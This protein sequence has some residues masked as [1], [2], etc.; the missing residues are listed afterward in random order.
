M[1]TF[2]IP[3]LL[4]FVKNSKLLE[5]MEK[6]FPT[7]G[8]TSFTSIIME[9]VAKSLWPKFLERGKMVYLPKGKHLP[10]QNNSQFIYYI[11][12][13]SCGTF[14]NT[15]EGKLLCLDIY[16]ENEF[17]HDTFFSQD[18]FTL[19]TETIA[20]EDLVVLQISKADFTSL[21][22]P[23]TNTSL[24]VLFDH[25]CLKKMQHRQIEMLTKTAEERYM[26]LLQ[27]FPEVIKRIPLFVIA[28]YLG[29]TI[30]SLS[31]IRS[32]LSKQ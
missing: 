8:I 30:Q 4:N 22:C 28:S 27:N 6:P 5:S 14:L 31:R 11:L 24:S 3:I 18:T 20:I 2:F 7:K 23:E 25:F 15:E 13:G 9:G 12:E 1:S 29:I 26:E 21:R 17:F 32:Q 16:M 19:P 10:A